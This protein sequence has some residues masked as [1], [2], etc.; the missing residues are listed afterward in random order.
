[1]KKYFSFSFEQHLDKL[2]AEIIRIFEDFPLDR[3]KQKKLFLCIRRIRPWKQKSR[4]KK[5]QTQKLF[6]CSNKNIGSLL[7]LGHTIEETFIRLELR[8]SKE[9]I[10]WKNKTKNIFSTQLNYKNL[11]TKWNFLMWISKKLF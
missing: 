2:F 4:V 8:L 7:W 9:V 6:F 5:N 1:M 11:K 10:S 3:T